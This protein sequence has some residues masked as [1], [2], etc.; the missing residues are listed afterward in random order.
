MT[1]IA[2]LGTG[3]LGSGMVEAMLR[4][5]CAVTVWNR[6]AATA[7]RLVAL[8]ATRAATAA[9]AVTTADE[10]HI[11][12]S[13]DA[14][15]DALLAQ[16]VPALPASALV[17]DHTTTAPAG[18]AA[19]YAAMAERGV[20]FLHA[21]VFM[22]PQMCRDA[23]GLMLTSGSDALH[24]RATPALAP[25]TGKVWYVGPRVEQAAAFKLFGNAMIFAM[26]AGIA[27]VFAM[28]QGL[29]MTAAEAATVFQ[30]FNVGSVV[31]M[32]AEKMARGDFSASFELTMARKDMRLMLEAAGS[33]AL[34][35]LPS[36]AARM[37]EA[38]A[39]GHGADDLGSI[40]A[41]NV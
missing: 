24:V 26:T 10:V 29:G 2:F 21:P 9:E 11:A 30:Q 34:A 31:G 12:L 33:E 32:R 18:T 20:A 16:I 6:T 19:R 25:M 7:D 13:D 4:R 40:A 37:D 39:Q 5:G 22:S 23:T 17:L 14:S 3:L 36:I 38:I 41:G 27:D 35:I 28:A 15:V 8:G 1:R